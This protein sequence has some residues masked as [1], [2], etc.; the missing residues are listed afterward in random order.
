M[1]DSTDS[2]LPATGI[3]IGHQEREQATEALTEHSRAG[4]L[5]IDEY[6]ERLAA[7]QSAVTRDEVLAV[8]GDLPEPR[9]FGQPSSGSE[10]A[11]PEGT[12]PTTGERLRRAVLPLGGAAAV[13]L[14]A[15]TGDWLFMLCVPP[16]AYA[17]KSA[18]R[19]RNR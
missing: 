1:S 11:V 17:V 3:R 5:T 10:V 4:R 16:V 19:N 13:G 15:A 9:P 7:V 14:T 18:L 8:F 6:G 2:R 12:A